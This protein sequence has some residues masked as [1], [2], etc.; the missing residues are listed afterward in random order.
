M[1]EPVNIDLWVIDGFNVLCAC[2]LKGPNRNH[3]WSE[4]AQSKLLAWLEPFA[5][6]H[7]VRVVFDARSESSPRCPQ[8]EFASQV[9]FGS[10][11]DDEIVELVRASHGSRVCVVTADRSLADRSRHAGAQAL[12]P[13]DFA[14]VMAR[15]GG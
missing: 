2:V 5:R 3:W 9:G 12:R 10:H 11:A 14:N 13:W 6:E 4:T 15:F 8:G 7:A 1:T